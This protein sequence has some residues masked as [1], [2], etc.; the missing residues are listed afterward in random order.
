MNI[1]KPEALNFIF[2]ITL[3]IV[4]KNCVKYILLY[5]YTYRYYYTII[6]TGIIIHTRGKK[7]VCCYD[8]KKKLI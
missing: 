5:Y 4:L 3:F 1:L 6:H 2:I 8:R 7:S